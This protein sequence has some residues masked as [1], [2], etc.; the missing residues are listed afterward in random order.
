MNRYEIIKVNPQGYCGGVLRAIRTVK[1]IREE[2][3]NEIITILGNL[4]HNTYVTKAL[5][6]YDI[7]TTDA[8]GVSRYDL[9]DTINEG[10]VVFT[11][12]GVHPSVIEKAKEKNLKYVDASCPFVL[13][14]QKVVNDKLKEGY[15]IFYIGKK[16]HP[17]AESVCFQNKDIYLIEKEKDIPQNIDGPI[18]VTNQTTMS[19]M[20]LQQ[21]FDV[22]KAMYPNA[23][24]HDEICNATRIR[25]Q[26]VLDLKDKN[27]DVLIVVGDP[28]SNNTAKLADIGKEAGISQVLRIN[29]VHELN[30][31]DLYHVHTIALT[32]GAS[33]PTY[34]TDQVIEYLETGMKTETRIQDI[35]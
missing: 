2:N 1:K 20:D 12:H 31:E 9:L 4:V 26:A 29:D 23:Q 19:I 33:T 25:Q 10:I 13:Q 7:N 3:P 22:I 27:V 28:S 21:L 34:L 35:L 15:T 11:A 16:G 24:I 14:T 30:P 17:E 6:F 8:K 18:F 32:S 5:E